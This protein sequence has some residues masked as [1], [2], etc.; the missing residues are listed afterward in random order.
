MTDDVIRKLFDIGILKSG[1]F[2]GKKVE[3]FL[4][5]LFEDKKFSD[6][7]KPLFLPAVDINSGEEI[8]FKEGDLTAV[9]IENQAIFHT[10]SGIF[11]LLFK[12]K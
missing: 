10:L 9:I 6:L 11:E 7:E 1:L 8:M 2:K 12:T 5:E 4:R 3:E